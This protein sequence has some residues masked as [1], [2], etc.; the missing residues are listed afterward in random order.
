MV[1]PAF[2]RVGGASVEGTIAVT[3]PV[4]VYDQLPD[5]MPSKAPA[6]VFMKSLLEKFGPDSASPFAGYSEDAFLLVQAAVPAALKAG[7]PGT[8]A[9]RVA[10]RDV[11]EKTHDLVGTHGVFTLSPTDHNGMDDRAAVLVQAVDGQWKLLR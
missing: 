3:G 2:L 6:S 9:F 11:M 5:S 1:S 10:L 4:V 8:E 7:E